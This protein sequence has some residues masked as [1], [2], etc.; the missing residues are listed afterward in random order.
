MLGVIILNTGTVNELVTCSRKTW[1]YGKEK[2]WAVK[3]N[4]QLSTWS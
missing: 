3:N 1:M 4:I 2:G